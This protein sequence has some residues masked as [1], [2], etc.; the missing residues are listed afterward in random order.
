MRVQRAI[1][2]VLVGTHDS[3]TTM[4]SSISARLLLGLCTLG[5]AVG[6]V[7]RGSAR[8][9]QALEEQRPPLPEWRLA[10]SPL[11]KVGHDG[12]E[13]LHR[14]GGAVVLGNGSVVVSDSGNRRLL[15]LDAT[16]RVS[17]TLG[18]QGDGPGEFQSIGPISAIGDTVVA[19][20][21]SLHRGTVWVPGS[22]PEVYMIPRVNRRAAFAYG[23]V[24][25]HAWILAAREPAPQ[26]ANQLFETHSAIALLR[27]R[28]RET[29]GLERR[30]F[31]YSYS[32]S[33]TTSTMS[34][35]T[36]Y[37]IPVLGTA[38]L[39]TAA[40]RWFFV[41][42][43]RPVIELHE[44][45]SGGPPVEIALPLEAR[46]PLGP[47]LSEYGDSVV[48]SVGQEYRARLR[49]V[50][51]GVE[52]AASGKNA[53]PAQRVVAMGEDIWIDITTP[54]RAQ[55]GKTVWFVA[56]AQEEALRATIT[57]D[58]DKTLLGGNASIAVLLRRTELE[59]EI[60]EV[61]GVVRGA[62]GKRPDR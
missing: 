49:A 50:Y 24:S 45:G 43:D 40:G 60:V 2:H 53:A 14:V 11:F 18:R 15:V 29:I 30:W 32:F 13:L 46:R 51:D 56:S 37:R 35:T 6:S 19:F 10:E 25:A 22:E 17:A 57:L 5:V 48:L 59:E 27:A 21:G 31:A 39:G 42:M 47:R 36:T 58:S 52:R 28:S 33:E 62:G 41:P 8:A 26:G 61:Y 9:L 34:G 7:G 38:H 44:A 20:D 12:A 55:N 16:G 23:A 1:V 54:N 4:A 3:M